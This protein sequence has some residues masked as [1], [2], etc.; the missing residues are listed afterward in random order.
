MKVNQTTT[1]EELNRRLK[2]IEGQ[3]RG[4]QKMVDEERDC[5]EIMQQL[6]AM[7]SALQAASQEFMRQAACDCVGRLDQM[8][9]LSRQA[10]MNDLVDLI[11]KVS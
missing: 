8:D 11:G 6:T 10:V 1:K 9:P 7:R 5:R 3:L 4:V 2:R